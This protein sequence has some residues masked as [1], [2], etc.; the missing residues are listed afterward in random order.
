MNGV[1]VWGGGGN[2][3]SG[4][5]SPQS[6]TTLY[7]LAEVASPPWKPPLEVVQAGLAGRTLLRGPETGRPMPSLT[8]GFQTL[9]VL[10]LRVLRRT[11]LLKQ[12]PF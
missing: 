8:L 4:T 3:C 2:F 1:C 10:T 12:P 6:C 11:A 7:H 9:S 5:Y